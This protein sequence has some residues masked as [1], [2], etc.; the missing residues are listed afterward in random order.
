MAK[1]KTQE[2]A[3]KAFSGWA[4]LFIYLI[5][6]AVTA[7]CCWQGVINMNIP[8]IVIAAV[9]SLVDLAWPIGFFIVNPNVS[10]AL[11][12]FGRYRGTVLENGFFWTNPFTV[13]KT[14]SLRLRNL[15][16][17]TLKVNDQSGSPIEIASIV[18]WKVQDTAHA[19]FDVDD[20]EEYVSLQCESAVRDM[21]S[22]YPYDAEAADVLSMRGSRDEVAEELRKELGDRLEHAGI[23][24][25]E[26]RISHLA[27]AAEIAGA[28]LR[29]QQ[30]DAVIAA[31]QKIVDGAVGMVEMALSNLK[32]HGVIELDEERR[33]AMVSNLMVVLCSESS[34]QPVVNT[35][36]LY[37]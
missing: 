2:V 27:Y 18:V 6:L 1:D 28:M 19:L 15:N 34:T 37:G 21:A 33:A 11:I 32:Q 14:V 3:F 7:V 13:R 29:R 25:L 26:A 10:R 22:K 36:T 23:E 31:R 4:M 8:L 9:I 5:F 30:A 35:G 16:T 24:V 20:Y 17:D 12:L